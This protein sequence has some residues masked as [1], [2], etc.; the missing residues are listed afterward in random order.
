M[1]VTAITCS[2][3]CPCVCFRLDNNTYTYEYVRTYIHRR[4]VSFNP[5]CFDNSV[6]MRP[7]ELRTAQI[8][9]YVHPYVQNKKSRADRKLVRVGTWT[10]LPSYLLSAGISSSGC[11]TTRTCEYCIM[12]PNR[13]KG[14]NYLSAKNRRLSVCL[15]LVGFENWKC[16]KSAN[17]RS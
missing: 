7:K 10:F 16:G 4:R 1:W 3:T 17:L 13:R 12:L 11:A 5:S 15:C 9:T 8:R 14:K 6:Y 2:G